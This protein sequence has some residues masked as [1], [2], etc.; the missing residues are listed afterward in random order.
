MPGNRRELLRT[1]FANL[2][3]PRPMT[4]KSPWLAVAAFAL[5]S[6]CIEAHAAAPVANNATIMACRARAVLPEDRPRVGLVL[7]G[8]GARGIA[9][10]SVLRKL[11]AMRVPVDCVAGTSMGA[12]VGALYASG[13]PVDEI[14]KTVLE[15]DWTQMFDDSLAR[16]ERSYRRK[17]DDTLVIAAPGPDVAN[18]HPNRLYVR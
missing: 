16:S 18:E 12:L 2:C 10:I 11:E 6:A 5:G 8:G 1:P 3:Y 17:T 15:M 7:G 4:L 14:E 9:H 13:M